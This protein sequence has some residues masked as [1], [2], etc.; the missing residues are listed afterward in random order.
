MPLTFRPRA[1]GVAGL[2]YAL[3][4]TVSPAALAQSAGY[5]DPGR[6]GDPASWRTPEYLADYGK[7]SMNADQAYAR[8]ITGRGVLV[9]SVDSGFLG[10]HPEFAGRARAI[11]NTG[12]YSSSS[13]R[14]DSG[15]TRSDFFT[16]GQPYSVPGTWVRGVNDDHGTHV[17]G[18]IV[19]NRDGT[20]THG[21]AFG[22]QL[23]ATNTNGTDSSIYGPNADYAY[24]KGAYG[25]LVA[26]GARLINS[27][28]GSPPPRDN[29]NTLAGLTAAYAPFTRQLSWLNAIADAG[30]AGV[31]QVVA[32]GNAGV[33][34]P[35]IRAALP[36]FQPDLEKD[37]IA[38]SG[39]NAADQTQFNRCGVAKYWCIAAPGRSITSTV[40][41]LTTGEA[42]Y[43]VKSGTSMSAPHVS[44]ALALVMERYA[45]MTN[46]QARDVLLTTATHLGT[47]PADVP[48]EVFGWGKID[49]GRAMNGPGQ[50]LGRFDANLGAGVADTWSNNISDAALRQR[51][52][53]DSAEHAAWEQTKAARG[54]TN[55]LPATATPDEQAEYGWRVARDQAFF[56][57]TYQGGLTKSG[58]GVLE[59]TGAST[60]TGTTEV[61]GGL[62]AVNGS[63]TSTAN[64]NAGGTLGGGGSVGALNVRGGGTVA[65]GNSIGTLTVAGNATFAAGSLYAVEVA[66][67]GR[68]DR[69]A[70]AGTAQ[71]A[72][73]TVSV[74]LENAAAPLSA[75]EARSLLGQ[76]YTILTAAGGVAGRFDLATPSYTF[77]GTDL[78]YGANAVDLSVSRNATTFA[79]VGTTRNQSAVGAGIEGLGAG[80]RLYETILVTTNPEAARSAFGSLAGDIHAS[81]VSAEFETAFFVREAI[82]DRMRW[83]STP[84]AP[85]SLSYGTLPATYTADLP[86]RRVAPSP[87]PMQVIDPRV[88]GFWG[89]GFGA[90]GQARTDGNAAGLNRQTSGFVLGGDVRLENGIR[91]GVAGGYTTTSLD[92][93]GRLQSATIESGF[94]GVYGGYELGPASLRLGAVY[95]DN[96]ARTRRTALF[97]GLTDTPSARTGGSTIQGFGEIGYRIFLGE[98]RSAL[99]SKDPVAPAVQALSY[100]EPFVGGAYVSIGRD[101]FVETGGL[102]ALTSFARDY[103]LGA[104]TAG[105]RAQTSLDL[106]FGTPVSAHGLIGYR[107]AFGDVVPKALLAFGTGPSFLTAGIPIDRDA[108]VAEAGLDLRVSANATIGIAYTGQVGS[109]A[110]DHAAKGNFTY[111]F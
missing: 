109:R 51:F 25:N 6:V 82:L 76:R 15:T 32:A 73:G 74:S 31:I 97:A 9:G 72:G 64:V 35:T 102:A 48:N 13:F 23:I 4:A 40:V 108:L 87:V 88:A 29:Y 36:Y 60:Y 54:W 86:G 8:G 81:T 21:V 44:G 3:C 96:S 24:F 47:G 1:L 63:I 45:Y 66:P 7:A 83:G 46:E 56:A 22:A 42:G 19:A 105:V 12:S 111:R 77:I 70:A 11:T 16:A 55:G 65:P 14:Y 100:I 10:T 52:V 94:G 85:E 95:A 18:T 75:A 49:L 67:G 99:V 79:S 57:R 50:F 106:G 26:Q 93:A 61:N 84:G 107:R 103:D 69:I 20:G 5:Q 39:L 27:S 71:I 68:S 104:A 34:N 92:T 59:L 17:D 28:W 53:E 43:G 78:A 80:N 89:Q 101:R 38:A 33:N 91:V 58:G 37:W 110:E 2:T 41:N 90:F 30:R 98:G 62:L